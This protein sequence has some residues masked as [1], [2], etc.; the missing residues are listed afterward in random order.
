MKRLCISLDDKTYETI[1]KLQDASKTSKADVIRKVIHRFEEQK[2]MLQDVDLETNL[3]YLDYLLSGEHVIL[4][5]DLLC[6]IFESLENSEFDFWDRVR[7]SGEAH[8]QQYFMKGMRN[9]Q[10]ILFYMSKT[11]LFRLKIESPNYFTLILFAPTKAVKKFIRIFLEGVFKNQMLNA[12]I[13]ESTD[14]LTIHIPWIK[15]EDNRKINGIPVKL[16]H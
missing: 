14:K 15:D 8:A 13:T 10:D 2:K 5:V 1:E 16:D 7:E 12:Q 4:D 6:A 9:I 3:I 11:N